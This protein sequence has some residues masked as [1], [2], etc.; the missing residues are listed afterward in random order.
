MF[1][2]VFNTN[3]SALVYPVAIKKLNSK[4]RVSVGEMDENTVFICSLKSGLV[5]LIDLRYFVITRHYKTSLESSNVHRH[6]VLSRW[7][8]Q[9]VRRVAD[10]RPQS[11]ET[12]DPGLRSQDPS[13]L[14]LEF[15]VPWETSL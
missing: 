6:C 10:T 13:S 2:C 1:V 11:C 7:S 14:A 3:S 12:L 15:P 8:Q 4:F 5:R 9:S